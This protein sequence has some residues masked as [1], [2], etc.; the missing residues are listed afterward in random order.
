MFERH[1]DRHRHEEQHREGNRDR[2]GIHEDL[3]RIELLLRQDL[4]ARRRRHAVLADQENMHRDQEQ[5]EWR[6]QQHMQSIEARECD[7]SDG[8]P[9]AQEAGQ[10]GA[11]H[12]RLARDLRGHH[13]PPIGAVVP[14]EQVARQPVRQG[15]EQQ[16]HPDHPGGLARLLVRA[17]EKDLHQVEHHDDDHHTGAPMV[18]AADET[19]ARNLGQDVT[20]A[21]VGVAGRGRIVEGQKGPGERLHQE[22]EDSHTA[23]YLVPAAR[24]GDLFIQE[25]ADRRLNSGAVVQPVGGIFPMAFHAVGSDWCN[26][27]ISSLLPCTLVSK[28]SSG[29]GAGPDTTFPSIANR[30]EWHGHRNSFLPSSQ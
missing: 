13:R 17:V 14:R 22:Q 7:H 28:R 4:V 15:D 26:S 3:V 23:E 12:R 11:D 29:R 19:A 24:C 20:Q 10:I 8:A 30:E 6:Q 5:R 1:P 25:L 2:D 21:V 16:H 18:Q 27:P 9:A